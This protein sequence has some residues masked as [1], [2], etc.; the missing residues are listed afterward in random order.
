VKN[1]Y[2]AQAAE[3]IFDKIEALSKEDKLQ[4]KQDN[5]NEAEISKEDEKENSDAVDVKENDNLSQEQVEEKLSKK[6]RKEK[7]KRAKYEAEL[8]EVESNKVIESTGKNDDDGGKKKNLISTENETQEGREISRKKQK[9]DVAGAENGDLENT[10]RGSSK[11]KHNKETVMLENG[12][13]E[14]SGIAERKK[15]KK[16]K[17]E[18]H[19]TET[20]D[21]KMLEGGKSKKK[22]KKCQ[23]ETEDICRDEPTKKKLRKNGR[24][25][26][27]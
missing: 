14:E 18:I 10:E 25:T 19:V 5:Q 12:T 22:R 17:K 26:W 6:E 2:N 7:R 16:S 13:S 21:A 9:G 20:G 23:E 3:S 15:S 27:N 1:Q 11:K 8:K 4:N 24:H